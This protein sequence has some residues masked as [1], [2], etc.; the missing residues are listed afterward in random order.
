MKGVSV[1]HERNMDDTHRSQVIRNKKDSLTNFEVALSNSGTGKLSF[2]YNSG[3]KQT[4]QGVTRWDATA[5]KW[6]GG[7]TCAQRRS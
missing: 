1:A 3:K 5:E 4:A 2:T 6:A 7:W